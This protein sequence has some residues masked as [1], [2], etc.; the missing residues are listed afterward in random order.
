VLAICVETLQRILEAQLS[1]VEEKL[2]FVNK[3][4]K[5]EQRGAV[6]KQES[7][8]CPSKQLPHLK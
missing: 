5:L 8:L 4:I 3:H 2:I 7:N 6:F 1:N